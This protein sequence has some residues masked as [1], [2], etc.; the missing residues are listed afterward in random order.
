MMTDFIT[1]D[2]C[3]LFSKLK[4]E[5]GCLFKGDCDITLQKKKKERNNTLFCMLLY[6]YHICK[7]GGGRSA[8]YMYPEGYHFQ[9]LVHDCTLLGYMIFN[10]CI[11]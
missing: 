10:S 11:S 6:K 9:I 7:N 5:F 8:N 3:H 2:F 1:Q 4:W